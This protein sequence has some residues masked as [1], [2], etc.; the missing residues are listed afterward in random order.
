M[1][2]S[3]S[4]RDRSWI[5]VAVAAG[6]LYVAIGRAF[7]N[8]EVNAQAWR[9]AAWIASGVVFA[10]HIAYEYFRRRERTPSIAL[11][12]AVGVAIGGF[13]LAAW[14]MIRSAATAANPPLARFAIALVAWP[15]VTA[16]PAYVAA[17]AA[18]AVLARL[19]P[20]VSDHHGP[21]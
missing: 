6:A 7:P 18:G 2:I 4:S 21:E 1:G 16:V 15:L 20:R 12:T 8:P 9:L 10:A 11:H 19:T 14:A 17:F 3:A 13:G 5:A